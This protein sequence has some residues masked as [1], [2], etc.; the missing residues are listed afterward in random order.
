[1][2]K[3]FL[4]LAE[5]GKNFMEQ[6]S[7]EK[8]RNIGIVAHIDAGKTTTTERVLYYTGRIYKMGDVDEGTAAMDWMEQEQERGI[9]ITAACTTCFWKDYRIN[10]IDT[11]GHVDFTVEV[12]RSLK[13]LD[14]C[15]VVFCGVGGV[16]PQSE[17][18]WRQA[19]RYK[20]PRI[21]FINKLDRVGSD[22]FGVVG[23]VENKL[24]APVLWL[25]LPI[26]SEEGFRG[27]IDLIQMRALIY[28]SDALE[29]QYRIEE[30][31]PDLKETAV[32]YREKLVER[33]AELDEGV[34]VNYIEDHNVAVPELK[35]AI[36]SLTVKNKAVPV[37]CGASLRNK[38]IQ[39]LLD[40]VCDYL[41]SPSD[42]GVISGINPL[43]KEMVERRIVEDEYFSALC[44]KIM[45][46]PFV[47]KL[48]FFRVYSGK[49]KSGSYIYNANKRTKERVQKLLRMHA[50]KQE[51]VE[52]VGAGDIVACVGLKDTVTGETICDEKNPIL[53]ESMHFPQPVISMAIEPITKSDQDRLSLALKK[54]EEE[55][56]TFKVSYNSETNQTLVS[57][58]GELH[59]EVII[60][61]LVREFTV[62][63][64]VGKPQVAYRETIKKKVISE[65]K[66]I[67]QTG[68]RGQYGRVVFEVEPGERNSGI[69]FNNRITRGVIPKE[70]IPAVEE[71]VKEAAQTGAIAGFPMIDV[72]VNLVDGA[73]HEVDSSDLAFHMAASLGLRE[74]IKKADPVI[75]EPIMDI[76][77]VTPEDYLG[78]VLGDLNSRRAQIVSIGQ[79]GNAKAIRGL[80]P[81]SEMFGYVTRIRSLTQGRG[82]YIM[83]PSFYQDVPRDIM[84]KIV[85]GSRL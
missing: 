13:V 81:L 61:R 79:R 54:L 73:Y 4:E 56:P 25:Q 83:E 74:A 7:L 64:N 11:P 24:G 9:T 10:I 58:M 84:E 67:Q 63:A 78:D 14:G 66:F 40:A 30:I 75:M 53:L 27:V 57:G 33:I 77:V 38:G 82:S 59:L 8:I 31:P 15:V 12:E 55:D 80:V 85:S 23:Q 76:E 60:D 3:I 19:D 21:A 2:Y 71:G 68:G 51:V 47:G 36:R 46:D 16:E 37:L 18:V 45:S 35:Q 50:N 44:F 70:F 29:T 6:G 5:T 52:E 34:M 43:T 41:P 49:F 32:K 48:S 26:G 39:P 17:T 65:G 20:V 62:K 42:V 22:F 72:I 69:V 28:D 1:M